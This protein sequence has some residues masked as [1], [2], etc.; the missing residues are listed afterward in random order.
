MNLTKCWQHLTPDERELLVQM[1]NYVRSTKAKIDM[2]MLP[3]LD[4]DEA[5]SATRHWSSDSV[6]VMSS[7]SARVMNIRY[8]LLQ[9]RIKE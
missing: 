1:I 8:M 5:I 7:D 9:A 2:P 6:R 4:I 3:F